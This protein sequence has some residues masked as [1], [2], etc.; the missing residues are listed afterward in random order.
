MQDAGDHRRAMVQH[1]IIARGINDPRV[2]AAMEDVPREAFIPGV[3][4]A[5]AY[6]DG[7][8]PIGAGQTISQ[9]YIVALMIEAAG[10]GAGDR[11]LEVGAG[12]GYAA[13]VIGRIAGHVYAI[14]RIA[15]LADR[16]RATIAALGYA[17][18]TI[19]C[20]DGTMG[21]PAA[22]PY[23]AIL[24]AAAASTVPPALFAQLETGGRLVMP[25]GQPSQQN[26]MCFTRKADGAITADDLGGVRFVPLI[27]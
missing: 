13:A 15:L 19:L 21:W 23:D 27:G 10:I 9:P 26:L 18:V 16:A 24:I 1:Q 2:I 3:S 11:V 7:P 25:V 22:A 20:G 5:L 6:A 17:N 4:L 8:L 12:S 14:E